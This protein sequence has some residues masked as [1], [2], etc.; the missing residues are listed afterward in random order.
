MIFLFSH[1]NESDSDTITTD[2]KIDNKSL[3]DTKKI[4]IDEI[5]RMKNVRSE[6][7]ESSQKLKKQNEIFNSNI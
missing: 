1:F 7:L 4:M 5:N 6:L 3:K 2:K